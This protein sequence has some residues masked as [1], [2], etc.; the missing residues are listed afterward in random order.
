MNGK[1][2]SKIEDYQTSTIDWMAKDATLAQLIALL[3]DHDT[4]EHSGML[5]TSDTLVRLNEILENQPRPYGDE[6]EQI[7]Q[8]KS[9]CRYYLRTL[10]GIADPELTNVTSHTDLFTRCEL[11][12]WHKFSQEELIADKAKNLPKAIIGLSGDKL[13]GIKM[14]KREWLLEPIL[15]QESSAMLYADAGV[16]KTWLSWELIVTIAG[17]G[18]FADWT[19][20]KARRVLV[21]DGE[22]NATELRDRLKKTLGRHP[23]EV[24]ERAMSNITLLS[25]QI[26]HWE[27]DFYDLNDKNYQD[28]LLWALERA[29]RENNPY[30]MIV[31]DNFSCLADVE[32]E[33]SSA[34]FNGIC[35]FLN[36]AKT[37]TTVLLVHHTKKNSGK[38]KGPHQDS[39]MTYRGS[40]KLGG[41]MEVCIGLSTPQE[42]Q[43]PL[44]SGAAFML[45]LE[46]FR[47]LRHESTD[48]RVFSLDPETDEWLI[49]VSEDE[50]FKKY[51]DALL[52]YKYPNAKHLAEALG[53]SP[54]TVSRALKQME[55]LNV[56][57]EV[58][59]QDC[60]G[61]AKAIADLAA[62][63]DSFFDISE[64]DSAD[65][66]EDF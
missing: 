56:L 54:S 42:A 30:E 59:I 14:K 57:G 13:L 43:R 4:L 38:S 58:T 1:V 64:F 27:T 28:R 36:R 61:K 39:G 44:H 10:H 66:E 32:D 53:V 46:K 16:G 47:G 18:T 21:V 31:L 63:D 48:P 5:F 52:S 50:R 2:V 40:S 24:A 8:L 6:L 60:F 23:V 3:N 20:E 29:E 65:D 41:I 62:K 37:M 33:N 51:K 49:Q 22:M 9:R 19:A 17:G 45:R 34:A 11:D 55:I 15:K 35:Q 12:Q 7:E 25:R 26:Q